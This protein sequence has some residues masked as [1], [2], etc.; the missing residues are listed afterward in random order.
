VTDTAAGKDRGPTAATAGRISV[1]VTLVAATALLL[2]GTALWLIERE[3]PSRTVDSWGDSL[4][5]AA[6]TLTTVGYGDHIPV[7]TAGRLIAVA[8]MAVGVAVLGGVAAVVAL[9]VAQAVAAAE[10]RALEAETEAVEHRIEARLDA[11]DARLDRIEQDLRIVAQRRA[12]IGG[13]DGRPINRL[14]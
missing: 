10:E 3:E 13:I 7:T 9:V 12:D 14:S 6:T 1:L 5:W 11:L 4:W 8:L 2:G